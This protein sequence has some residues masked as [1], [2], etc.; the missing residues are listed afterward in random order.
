MGWGEE[1]QVTYLG[2]LEEEVLEEE[3]LHMGFMLC[4]GVWLT[5]WDGKGGVFGGS[6]F[7]VDHLSHSLFF[8][9][10]SSILS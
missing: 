8:L 6:G 4:H 3:D 10:F 1:G 9:V 2:S 7:W 5:G